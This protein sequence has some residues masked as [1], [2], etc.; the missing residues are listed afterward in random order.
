MG[1]IKKFRSCVERFNL[2]I[3]VLCGL[4]ILAMGLI[5]AYEVVC[6]YFFDAPTSWAQETSIYLFMWTML[7][8]SAYTLMQGKHVRIDLVFERLPRR[9]QLVLDALTSLAGVAFCAVV[10]WQAWDMI[11]S[12][13]RHTKVSATLLRVPMW[14]PLSS[15]LLGF[16]LLTFQFAFIIADRLASLKEEVPSK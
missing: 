9:V 13:I 15:L 16:G 8:G 12:A 10:T 3:G 11:A 2:A 1:Q 14:I 5:L 7:A 6:R 4:A